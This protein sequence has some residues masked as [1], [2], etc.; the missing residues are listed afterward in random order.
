MRLDAEH[1]TDA[2]L[3]Q[4]I[5][6]F[7]KNFKRIKTILSVG[8]I[9]NEDE[10]LLILTLRIGLEL[11]SDFLDAQGHFQV[12]VSFKEIDAMIEEATDAVQNRHNYD[13]AV[14]LVRQNCGLPIRNKWL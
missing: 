6:D 3:R 4:V 14:Q 7:K 12:K 9:W 13:L 8:E 1:L 10:I 11:I 5:A 2:V